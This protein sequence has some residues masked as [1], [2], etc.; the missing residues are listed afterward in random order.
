MWGFNELCLNLV[1]KWAWAQKWVSSRDVVKIFS[2]IENVS[3]EAQSQVR[4]GSSLCACIIY[5]TQH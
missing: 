5:I 3:I 2:E 1:R 4:S